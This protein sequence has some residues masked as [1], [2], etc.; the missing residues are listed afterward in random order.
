LAKNLMAEKKARAE[1]IDRI[2]GLTALLTFIAAWL[3]G[4][5]LGEPDP[6]GFLPQAMPGADRFRKISSNTYAA[7]S[8]NAPGEIIGYVTTGVANGYGGPLLV[9]AGVDMQSKITGVVIIDHRESYDW[10]ERVDRSDFI[11]GLVGKSALD[12][13]RIGV[14]IDG[15]SGATYT[16]WAIAEATAR[17]GRS[18]IVN[19]LRG[20]VPNSAPTA[21][22]FGIPEITLIALFAA[23]YIGHRRKF[24]HKKAIRWATMLTGLVVLGFIYNAP[25]TLTYVNQFLLGYWPKWQTHLYWYLLFGG[26]LFVF[27]VENKNPYCE[28]FCP[29]GAAQECMGAVGGA[30]VRT[31]NN[32]RTPLI[33]TQRSLAW[34]AIIVALI[35]RNP[36][37]SSYEIFGTLF[38]FVGDSY[39]FFLL[40]TVLFAALFLKRPWC[41]YLCPVRP[42]TDWIRM[43]RNWVYG[44]WQ[45]FLKK[46]STSISSR[47]S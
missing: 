8:R 7:Y 27:T 40:A 2:L 14:D 33:W 45:T 10:M 43:F 3:V 22:R 37:L 19:Y 35:L 17:A 44:L 30:K 4:G 42:V 18:V 16:T 39:Q 20:N 1:R 13:F 6:Q 28:W 41:A 11:S 5:T 21:I 9:A 26:I 23:G 31:S 29:F 12:D 34:F 46:S 36:S 24:K 32:L 38:A 47:F 25:F 15:V